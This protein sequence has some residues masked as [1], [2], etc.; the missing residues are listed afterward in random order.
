MLALFQEKYKKESPRQQ[1]IKVI[2]QGLEA[3]SLKKCSRWTQKVRIMGKPFPGPKRYIHHP[4]A[5]EM[6][7][8][9]APECV[10][11]KAAQ[12][13]FTDTMLD[14]ALFTVDQLGLDVLYV[15]PAKT[16]DATDFSS[17]RFNPALEMSDYLSRIFTNTNNVGLKRA[18]NNSLYIRGSRS[19]SSLV[20]IPVGLVILD[21]MN[22][23]A[24]A[25]IPL[26]KERLSGQLQK[27]IWMISTPTVPNFGINER[28]LLSDQRHFFFKCPHCSRYIE[29]TFPDSII[30]RG[31]TES[32]PDVYLSE[33]ICTECKHAL[34]HAAKPEYLSVYTGNAEWKSTVSNK[35]IVGYHIPQLYSC[36]MHPG[37]IAKLWIGGQTDVVKEQEFYNSKLGLPHVPKGSAITDE[38]LEKCKSNHRLA[39][40]QLFGTGFC[41]MGVD[42]GTDLHVEVDLWT[43]RRDLQTTDINDI[44]TGRLFWCGTVKDFAE[45]DIF[46]YKYKPIMTVVD[47]QPETRAALAFAHRFPGRV[48]LC[49]Y[50]NG[51]HAREISDFG[52]RVTVDRTCWLDLSMSRFINRTL[53]L[54]RDVPIMYTEHVKHLVRIPVKPSETS[55]DQDL[56][57][58]YQKTGDDHMAHAR[59]Y[60]EIALRLSASIGGNS[61]ITERVK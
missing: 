40:P 1:M 57:F 49:H 12:M 25:T 24:E 26:V 58:K 45:L 16:P 33:L 2:S 36:V 56:T 41:T 35:S 9:R 53:L 8:Q 44:A 51:A 38:I 19:K 50:G 59:N 14:V 27:Q 31:D 15:L 34:D 42:V 6:T 48:K 17:S 43:L 47:H 3:A 46:M 32:D 4:W 18:G 54:P 28:F 39:D 22:L 55:M 37:D 20:S 60:S 13:A 10:G 52:E 5:L 7:D 61:D 23:F 29:L 30:I 11:Q 21:E